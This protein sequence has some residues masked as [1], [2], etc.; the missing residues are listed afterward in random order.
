MNLIGG[1]RHYL[2]PLTRAMVVLFATGWLG[3]AVQPCLA[4]GAHDAGATL[5]G[6]PAPHGHDCPHCPPPAD[7]THDCGNAVALDCAAVGE[8]A[9]AAQAQKNLDTHATVAICAAPLH[10]ALAEAGRVGPRAP[11]DP[12]RHVAPRTLQQ[13]YCSYLK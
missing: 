6:M 2:P 5:P 9:L 8:P 11:P 4:A 13:R 3:L 7:D 12:G 10:V 1:F